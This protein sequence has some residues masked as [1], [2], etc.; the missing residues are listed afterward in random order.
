MRL[1]KQDEAVIIWFGRNQVSRTREAAEFSQIF[2]GQKVLI[3]LIILIDI[4]DISAGLK[5][6]AMTIFHHGDR[7]HTF[8]RTLKV[9]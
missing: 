3:V 2:R 1:N 4:A 5:P 9:A 7:R 6:P 8:L